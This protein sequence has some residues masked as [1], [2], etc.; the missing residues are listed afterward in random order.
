MKIIRN[1]FIYSL[2]ITLVLAGCKGKDRRHNEGDISIK[3]FEQILFETPTNK[4]PDALIAFTTEFKSPLLNI[5]PD[6]PQYMAQ[7]ND[8]IADS[9]VRDIYRIT[10]GK[11]ENLYWLES[12]LTEA[13]NKAQSLDDEIDYKWF[14]TFISGDFD[15]TQ[16][17]IA[18]RETKSVLVHIDQY[19]LGGMEKYDYFW[20]PMYIVELSDSVYLASDIMA[21]IARQFTAMPD[22]DN[23]T[24]LDLMI[25]EGKVLYFLDQV[26]PKKEDRLKIRYT[27]EQMNWM[28]ANESNVWAY[29]IKN[30]LLYEKDYSRYHN[31]VD[32]APKTN[33]FKDS[34]PRTTH[35]IG[36]QI[37]RSY[38]AATKCS[39]KEL[40]ENTDSQNIL[41]VSKYKP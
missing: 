22:E 33:A 3:R 14:A 26:M 24:M 41:Q 29:F 1:V 31:F 32:E 10:N 38:M 8:F 27:E 15:Y 19:A 6:N 34:A 18:P 13:L 20:T 30:N 9:T 21:E 28:K 7:L 25:A 2:L 23:V 5:Y 4:L 39:M 17:I 12:E 16:R 35:Y 36:W 40:F 37:V 11:F